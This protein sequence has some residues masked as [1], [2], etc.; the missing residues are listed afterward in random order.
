MPTMAPTAI[1]AMEPG[2]RPDDEGAG[3]GDSVAVLPS[4]ILPVAVGLTSV[5]TPV[6]V[7]DP[8]TVLAVAV[9]LGRV[10]ALV[11]RQLGEVFTLT[12]APSQNCHNQPTPESVSDGIIAKST[13]ETYLY[14]EIKGTILFRDR[15]FLNNAACETRDECIAGT[16]AC[17]VGSA[18]RGPINEGRV[19]AFLLLTDEGQ[20][21]SQLSLGSHMY[22]M[23]TLTAQVGR[24]ALISMLV[25]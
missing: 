24:T 11:V 10:P 6:A 3:I 18:T 21:Q 13:V 1:P 17:K 4:P 19:C 2:D 15:T 25:C 22:E 8:E 5:L 9:L 23:A 16:K 14:Y 7:A 20:F 12:P